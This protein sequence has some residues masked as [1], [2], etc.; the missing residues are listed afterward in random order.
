MSAA[1]EG[2]G[3][4]ERTNGGRP[5]HTPPES[6]YSSPVG[7]AQYPA[8]DSGYPLGAVQRSGSFSGGLPL[9]SVGRVGSGSML[10]R[11]SHDSFQGLGHEQEHGGGSQGSGSYDEAGVRRLMAGMSV[12]APD[13]APHQVILPYIIWASVLAVKFSGCPKDIMWP[14]FSLDIIWL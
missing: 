4:P 5:L 14:Y 1:P 3:S 12:S 2:A 7:S 13:F 8:H 9:G 11:L 6:P 10:R